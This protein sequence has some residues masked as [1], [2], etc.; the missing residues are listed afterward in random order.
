[1]G[2]THSTESQS[3]E[4]WTELPE[5][6]AGWVTDA[7]SRFHVSRSEIIRRAVEHFL[8]HVEE[9]QIAIDERRSEPRATPDWG[10]AKQTLEKAHC[11]YEGCPFAGDC[12]V[13]VCP[14]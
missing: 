1:M 8:G 5:N 13:E 11:P 4:L 2:D 10:R 9:V 14:L 7:A 6:L 3:V 12:P